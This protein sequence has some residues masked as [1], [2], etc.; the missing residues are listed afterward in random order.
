[1]TKWLPDDSESRIPNYAHTMIG[2]GA[3]VLNDKN[4]V[5]VVKEFYRKRPQWKLPGGYVEMSK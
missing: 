1:M 2:A 5:L 4:Q 3:V